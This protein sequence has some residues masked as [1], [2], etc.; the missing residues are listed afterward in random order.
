V[1][2]LDSLDFHITYAN[3]GVFFVRI[4]K[5]ILILTVHVDNCMFTGSSMKL[6]M[7]YK[8][9]LNASYAL[10]DLGPVH[11]LLEIKITC[12]RAT[13]TISLSQSTFIDSIISHFSLANAKP[14]GSPMIP[15]TTYT[16]Q[17]MPS[18]PE[19]TLRMQHMLSSPPI[20]DSMSRP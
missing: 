4:G 13:H 1:C 3:P 14:F 17:D 15:G 2:A 8:Q 10:T 6:I 12:D 11:W 9:K 5:H 19:E 20:G 18:T 16:K 7:Q